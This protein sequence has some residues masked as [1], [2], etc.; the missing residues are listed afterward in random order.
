MSIVLIFLTLSKIIQLSANRL[1]TF[2]FIIHMYLYRWTLR[3]LIISSYIRSIL[4]LESLRQSYVQF[5]FKAYIVNVYNTL[6]L[7]AENV[8][9]TSKG[10][11]PVV[12]QAIFFILLWQS[13]Y[14]CFHT[15]STESAP[16]YSCRT[17]DNIAG[18]CI[19]LRAC[20]SLFTLL[21]KNPLT[22]NDRNH[23]Q[24]SQCGYYNK[25]PLVWF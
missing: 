8:Q 19:D 3:F 7:F 6:G 11:E 4:L 16:G 25:S 12:S 23:L 10:Q 2:M 22:P 9:A 13:A 14:V 15:Q 24:R 21:Q 1:I 18:S 17:P 5:Q 20:N